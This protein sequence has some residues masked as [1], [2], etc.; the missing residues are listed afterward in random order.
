MFH[1]M[2][3]VFFDLGGFTSNL[4]VLLLASGVTSIGGVYL[5]RM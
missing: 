4:E 2:G 3:S 1:N 5:R